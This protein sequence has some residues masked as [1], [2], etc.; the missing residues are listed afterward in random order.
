MTLLKALDELLSFVTEDAV[1]H[2][3]INL[4]KPLLEKLTQVSIELSKYLDE[5]E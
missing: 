4:P 5:S 2:K 3:L 1:A